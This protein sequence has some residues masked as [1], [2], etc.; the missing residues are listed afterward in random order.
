MRQQ[1]ILINEH[2]KFLK[3]YFIKQNKDNLPFCF[4][5]ISYKKGT[6]ILTESQQYR[7]CLDLLDNGC[8]VYVIE[9]KC[10][11]DQIY[12]KLYAQYPSQIYFLYDEDHFTTTC[13]SY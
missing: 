4:D 7:L 5:Y 12:D 3:D 2:S 6:D 9:Q 1:I 8:K 13:I 11:I 10:I